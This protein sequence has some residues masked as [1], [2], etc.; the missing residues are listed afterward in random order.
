MNGNAIFQ[1]ASLH[2]DG[3]SHTIRKKNSQNASNSPRN[4]SIG[5]G[6]WQSG[7]GGSGG[8]PSNIGILARDVRDAIGVL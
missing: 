4:D 8:Y 1:I 7:Q 5:P 3:R 6:G 2:F